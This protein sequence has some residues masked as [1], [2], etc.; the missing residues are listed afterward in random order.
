MFIFKIPQ[1]RLDTVYF[2]DEKNTIPIDQKLRT[3]LTKIT[4]ETNPLTTED[5]VSLLNPEEKIVG[6]FFDTNAKSCGIRVQNFENGN[7][8]DLRFKS[9]FCLYDSSNSL[10]NFN[11]LTDVKVN[12]AE[13]FGN[14]ALDDRFTLVKKPEARIKYPISKIY[15]QTRK[16]KQSVYIFWRM[17]ITHWLISQNFYPASK[18]FTSDDVS[19]FIERKIQLEDESRELVET[20]II[21]N[22]VVIEQH[23]NINDFE[24]YL[25]KIYPNRFYEGA[26]RVNSNDF[27]YLKKYMYQEICLIKNYPPTFADHFLNVR[28]NTSFIRMHDQE[29][30]SPENIFHNNLAIKTKKN[31]EDE[32]FFIFSPY[33]C[34]EM[35]PEYKDKNSKERQAELVIIPFRG[36]LC[37]IRMTKAGSSQVAMKICEMWHK[38][39]QVG[40]YYETEKKQTLCR[41]FILRKKHIYEAE[42]N[43]EENLRITGQDYWILIY[44]LREEKP[45]YAAILPFKPL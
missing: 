5:V 13:K 16:W 36:F 21:E 4:T 45:V 11:I 35:D 6:Q 19:E 30:V 27:A 32:K 2:N 28:M 3:F 41:K 43:E 17:V 37:Y 20:Q 24:K 23:T 39:R 40:S 8:M 1:G 18:I 33:F 31:L 42:D 12:V 38:D 29:I 44:T 10:N 14:F 34:A 9:Q 25:E 7:I 22:L 26:F 15:E